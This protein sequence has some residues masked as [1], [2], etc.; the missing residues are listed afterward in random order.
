MNHCSIVG[1]DCLNNIL[2]FT[3]NATNIL[4]IPWI[5]SENPKLEFHVKSSGVARLRVQGVTG[6][7]NVTA[8]IGV[9]ETVKYKGMIYICFY[10]SIE[11]Y[12]LTFTGL[13]YPN[14]SHTSNIM[15]TPSNPPHK[16]LCTRKC[17]QTT[18]E[19]ITGIHPSPICDTLHD[20]FFKFSIVQV[21]CFKQYSWYL[22]Y[23][24]RDH[25]W[26]FPYRLCVL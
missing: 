17:T 9:K 4:R 11:D 23:I 25:N 1:Q 16:E 26:I 15:H 24:I 10:I 13:A 22:L 6:F 8:F 2:N 20:F 12:R 3:T 14:K 7:P 21:L 18:I 19:Y 5:P